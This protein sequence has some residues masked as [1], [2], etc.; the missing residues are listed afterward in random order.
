MAENENIK[1]IDSEVE[2]GKVIQH[3]KKESDKSTEHKG[4]KIK[5]G[6]YDSLVLYE[7]SESELSIIERGSPNSTYLNFAIFSSSV[8]LSF[9]ATLLTFDFSDKPNR[10]YIV[11]VVITVIGILLGL[12]LLVIWFRTKNQFDEVIKKIKGRMI[13]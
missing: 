7:V 10:T 2:K 11:F 9:L 4:P 12:L 5:L 3:F 8:G 6:K 1:A 13:E